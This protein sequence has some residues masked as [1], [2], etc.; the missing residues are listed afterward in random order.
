MYPL[1]GQ[2]KLET[3]LGGRHIAFMLCLDSILLIIQLNMGP[4]KGRNVTEVGSS[5]IL[6][7][8]SKPVLL[9][10]SAESFMTEYPFT[11]F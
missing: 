9:L 8:H 2:R 7:P 5:H 1:I 3:F 10:K 4:T 6:E 11:I